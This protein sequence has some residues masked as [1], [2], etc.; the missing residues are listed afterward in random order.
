MDRWYLIIKARLHGRAVQEPENLGL[1]LL[2]SSSCNKEL[3]SPV[4]PRSGVVSHTGV[5][6]EL[7]SLLAQVSQ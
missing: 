5:V 6:P 4:V 7:Q 1:G 3:G 2:S